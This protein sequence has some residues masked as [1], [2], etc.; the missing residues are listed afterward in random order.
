MLRRF[1]LVGCSLVV[2]SSVLQSSIDA[3]PV[4]SKEAI[5]L[6]KKVKRIKNNMAMPAVLKIMGQPQKQLMHER[7]LWEGKDYELVVDFR[8]FKSGSRLY[9]L[10][11]TKL[12]DAPEQYDPSLKEL[13][14]KSESLVNR[15]IPYADVV[16]SLGTPNQKIN[17][18]F[19]E[20][21][22][23]AKE[24]V[25]IIVLANGKVESKDYHDQ[26][27]DYYNRAWIPERP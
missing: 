16:K 26:P 27:K 6:I 10:A 2:M 12:P 18:K 9:N 8:V 3:A 22:W 4:L 21:F 19:M 25:V 15:E 7:Y 11:F 20:Y 1:F 5:T 13:L 14:R 23:Q 17:S 24:A